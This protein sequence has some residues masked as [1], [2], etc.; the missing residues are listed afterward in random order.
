MNMRMAAR[1]AG[2]CES[3]SQNAM[4]SAV[5][6]YDEH[7]KPNPK[8]FIDN[9]RGSPIHMKLFLFLKNK[10]GKN[11][12]SDAAGHRQMYEKNKWAAPCFFRLKIGVPKLCPCCDRKCR[13]AQKRSYTMEDLLPI[14]AQVLYCVHKILFKFY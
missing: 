3:I 13:N 4:P 1:T 11:V 5:E 9:L 10:A 6:G 2:A 7:Y 8:A 12:T 14:Q